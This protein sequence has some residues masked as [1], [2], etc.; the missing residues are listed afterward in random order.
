[1]ILISAVSAGRARD[2]QPTGTSFGQRIRARTDGWSHRIHDTAL[3]L[4][5]SERNARVRSAPDADV[6]DDLE[7]AVQHRITARIQSF[8]RH[9]SRSRV[10]ARERVIHD[11]QKGR[12]AVV[13]FRRTV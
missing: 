12:G 6:V 10:R 8:G 11:G 7:T 1:M 13:D 9:S 5:P 2:A 4:S 3:G